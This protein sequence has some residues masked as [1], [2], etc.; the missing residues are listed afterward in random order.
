MII[1][2]KVIKSDLEKLGITPNKSRS[3]RFPDVPDEFLPSFI[4]GV[5]DGDGWVQKEGYQMNITTASEHFAN[6]LMAVFK[7]WRLIPK[8]E[9]RFTDLNRPYFRVAVNGKEQIKRLATILYANSNEL[10]V[11]SKRERMLL[12]FTFKRGINR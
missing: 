9:K 6:S 1:N 3:V 11:P 12:H 5:I 4:R 10:C 8:R 2:S 7:N